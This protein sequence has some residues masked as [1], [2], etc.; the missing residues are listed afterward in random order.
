MA[1]NGR[2]RGVTPLSV[3]NLTAG[4]YTIRVS[5]RGYETE[6]RQVVVS[7]DR[8]SVTLNFSLGRVAEAQPASRT[9]FFGTLSV[10]SLPSGA[11]V[12]VDG[13]LVGTTPVASARIAAGSHVVRVDRTGFL[14]WTSPI[15]IVTGQN[16]RVTASLERES[17]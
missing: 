3:R 17:R 16:L 6:Q 11:R 14:P 15:Q 8:P 10:E 2:V 13:R 5:R 9:E 1:V 12:F 7:T 4:R